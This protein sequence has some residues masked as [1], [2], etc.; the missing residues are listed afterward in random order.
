MTALELLN[1]CRAHGREAASL[2]DRLEELREAAT[3]ASVALDKVGGG[4]SGGDQMAAYM[5]R[6]DELSARLTQVRKAYAAEQMAIILITGELPDQQRRCLRAFYCHRR[7]ATAIAQELYCSVSGVYK[8]L[9]D[10]R[11]ALMPL[12]P[13][14]IEEKMPG[15]YVR[16]RILGLTEERE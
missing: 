3:S 8:A 13:Q 7:S 14:T 4:G 15:W 12:P 6:V 11:D 9:A 10:G 16:Q 2:E 1:A 5:A